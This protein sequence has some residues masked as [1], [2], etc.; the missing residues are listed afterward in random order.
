MRPGTFLGVGSALAWF[1]FP[2]VPALLGSSYHQELNQS[3]GKS[4]GPD[5]RDWDWVNW[6][7]LTGPLLGYGFLAGATIDLPDDPAR[8]GIRGWLSRRS[9]W[10]GV[11]PWIGF[12]AWLGIDQACRVFQWTIPNVREWRWLFVPQVWQG[13]W[14]AWALFVAL[15]LIGSRSRMAGYS[16]PGP[17]SVG[18][19]GSVGSGSRSPEDLPWRSG[20]SARCSVRSGRSPRPGE[21]I[22]STP[23]SCRP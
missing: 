9:I 1:V 18:L 11:G 19:V 13:N 4:H 20:S 17:R 21:A 12:L 3:I 10:V 8:R 5:P 6:L 2:M 23:G 14:F 7:V 22:S 15:G 16:W